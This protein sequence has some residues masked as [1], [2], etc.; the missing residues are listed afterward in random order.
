[1]IAGKL[2][3]ASTPLLWVASINVVTNW[4]G[5]VFLGIWGT[6]A[7]VG[8]FNV[9]YRTAM[10]ITF[11][12]LAVNSVVGP[13]FAAAHR[14]GD[15]PMM[16]R[17][18][19]RS[20]RLMTY[21]A[22]PMTAV[23]L[24]APGWVMRLFGGDFETGRG[25]LMILAVAQFINVAAGSLGKLLIMTGHERVMRNVVMASAVITI[26]AC[27]LLIPAYGLLGAAVAAAIAIVMRNVLSGIA[28]YSIF[29]FKPLAL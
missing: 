26:V 7:E 22:A 25:T 10:L 9:A 23:L 11:V 20:T 5:S 17:L 15:S 4:S 29:R 27:I 1:M 3:R 19:R 13:K 8:V 6:E 12:L 21:W 16:E 2:L 24:L 18:L 28:V 14:R